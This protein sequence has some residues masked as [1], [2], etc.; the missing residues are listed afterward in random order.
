MKV[1]FQRMFEHL[2]R[3]LSLSRQ[4]L[5]KHIGIVSSGH[6]L[7]ICDSFSESRIRDQDVN[8]S[9]VFCARAAS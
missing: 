8:R 9:T 1:Y 3:Y 7:Y 6:L 2:K 4:Q 5:P